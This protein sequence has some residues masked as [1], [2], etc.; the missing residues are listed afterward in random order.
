MKRILLHIGT[1]KTGS[2]AIQSFLTKNG[3]ALEKNGIGYYIPNQRFVPWPGYS[4]GDFLVYHTLFQLKEQDQNAL[5][6][7]LHINTADHYYML[8]RFTKPVQP[9]LLKELERFKAY[10]KKFDTLIL[11]EEVFYHSEVFYPDFWPTI[12]KTLT[13]LFEEN[14]Q[15][16]VIVYLRRQ[17]LWVESKFKEGVSM[18]Y[19]WQ[20]SIE[21][22][23]QEYKRIGF[24]DYYATLQR[25]ESTFGKEHVLIRN[26]QRS[27]LTKHD[28][29]YD[30]F[31]TCKIAWDNAYRYNE[32]RIANPSLNAYAT[33]AMDYI[34]R[35]IPITEKQKWT[36]YKVSNRYTRQQP[37]EKNTTILSHE[38]R[39]EILDF[40]QECNQKISKEYSNGEPFFDNTIK[41]TVYIAP[42]TNRDKKLAKQF[43]T[44]TKR[45]Y[46]LFSLKK[47]IKRFLH[48]LK[49]C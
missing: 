14:I 40:C 8:D 46:P 27:N 31:A 5:K 30:F 43:L 21:Q 35:N 10:A 15:I 32:D 24:F 6:T 36:L 33:Y 16:D 18:I 39:Q 11:S 3:S 41:E 9:Y 22:T 12:K 45:N 48:Y 42:D 17:D 7:A 19:P 2:T 29:I 28:I 49:R 34:N 26:Y 1:P 20:L 25:L 38:L 4:N 23:I 13:N 37:E 47:Q 44:Q